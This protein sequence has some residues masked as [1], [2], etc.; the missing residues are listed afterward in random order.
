MN[1]PLLNAIGFFD[2][3]K[4][5]FA[6]AINRNPQDVNNWLKRSRVPADV[7]PDIERATGGQ[8]RCEAL[9]PD[10]DWNYLRGTES[11]AA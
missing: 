10:V 9:R 8:V 1:T 7:C 5:A 4:S 2:G 3:N 11:A 6:R